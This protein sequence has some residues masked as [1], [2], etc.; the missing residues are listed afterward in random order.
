MA[1]GEACCLSDG[2]F[3]ALG[4]IYMYNRR[5]SC[6]ALSFGAD[7]QWTSFSPMHDGR[8]HFACAAVTKCIIVAGGLL[9]ISAELYD[10]VL[11]RWLRLPCGFPHNSGLVD[12][13]AHLCRRLVDIC[14]QITRTRTCNVSI[15]CAVH[16][17]GGL[18]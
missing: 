8:V 15:S 11:G 18:D 13:C 1:A 3:A 5:S 16:A 7:A 17:N 10:E 14:A 2:H 4:G 6:E 12:I 9:R